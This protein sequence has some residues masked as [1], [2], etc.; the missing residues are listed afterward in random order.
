MM[1]CAQALSAG[2]YPPRWGSRTTRPRDRLSVGH[3]S[4]KANRPLSVRRRIVTVSESGETEQ[5]SVQWHNQQQVRYTD[6]N[7]DKLV[8]NASRA[9]QHYVQVVSAAELRDGARVLDVGCGSGELVKALLSA[10]IKDI[11]AV[12]LSQ[13]MVD[14][15][16]SKYPDPGPLGNEPGVRVVCGD[17]I[18]LPHFY[19]PFDT[20]FFCS[21]FEHM[22]SQRDALL[23]ASLALRQ[24]GKIII[25]HPENR[26]FVKSEFEKSPLSVPH[27]LPDEG[28]LQALI[29]DL[30]LR[31]L[32]AVDDETGYYMVL[33]V[34]ELYWLKW[35]TRFLEGEVVTGFGRGSSKM[36]VP[37]ANINPAEIMDGIEGLPKGVYF[38]WAKLEGESGS[39]H[40]MVMNL[41]ERP[42]FADGD[43]ITA[44][45]HIMHDYNRDFHGERLRVV[46]LGY[47]RPELRFAS[48]TELVDRIHADIG[49]SKSMLTNFM[50]QSYQDDDYFKY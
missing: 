41:G 42:T 12:D 9:T 23:K 5:L 25:S 4:L 45:V 26:S 47:L 8:R 22:F 49:T 36:G 27:E 20:V 48:M 29:S 44:E 21:S 30:P 15:V 11:T 10:D 34:P 7:L 43:G 24:G 16:Q 18:D 3:A 1:S 40:P 14:I 33:Q 19:G 35:G 37:T 17:G 50:L 46:V 13:K 6:D 39:A 32:E 2:Y 28:T 38:G 31:L